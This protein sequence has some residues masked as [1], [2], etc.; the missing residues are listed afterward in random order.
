M[1]SSTR[2]IRRRIRSVQNTKKITKAMELVASAKMRKVT[3]ALLN[4][5][6]Y[7]D[8]A[9]QLLQS[10]STRTDPDLH[11]LLHRRLPIRRQGLVVISTNRGLVGAFNTNL[12][13]TAL[14]YGRRAKDDQVES[15]LILVGTKGRPLAYR[16]GFHAAADFPKTDVVTS[17][18]A[19][20][21]LARFVLEEFRRGVYDRISVVFMDFR[22]TLSQVTRIRQLLPLDREAFAIGPHDAAPARIPT[23]QIF[24]PD[25]D[26]VLEVLLWRLVEVQ[27]YRALLETNASEQAARMMAMRNATDSAGEL[28]DDLTLTFNQ[29]RQAA[30]TQDL[31]EIS[32]GRAALDT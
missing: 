1:A 2:D 25:A 29:V 12:I 21:P 30:I 15:D 4:T 19:I 20:R 10:V 17:V 26:V 14:G 31:A 7:T 28:I 27:L 9:W 22:S 32:A 16:Y 5:R 13:A 11:P 6:P 24:E 3:Q 23:E 8:L 18:L